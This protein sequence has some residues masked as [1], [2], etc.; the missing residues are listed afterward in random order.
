[1]VVGE[2]QILGQVKD[3]FAKATAYKSTG[4]LTNRLFTSAFSRRQAR[5]QRDRPRRR[6]RVGQLRGHCAGE[7]DLRRARRPRRAD[8]RRR[9]D[10]QAHRR[11]PAGAARAV[12]CR[13]PA[14]RSAPRRRSRD[15]MDGRAVPWI[16]IDQ[17]LA[18]AD[19]VI[20]ATGAR[21]PVLTRGRRRGRDAPRRDRPLFLIDIAVPRDVEPDVGSLDQVFLYNIDDLRSDRE[22]EPGAAR[23]ASSNAPRPSSATRWQRFGTWMQSR[24]IIPTV[25]ALR[26]RFEAIR[27]SELQ[28]LEPKLAAPAAGG[29]RARRRDHPPDRREAAADADRTAQVGRRRAADRRVCGRA[30]PALRSDHGRQARAADNRARERFVRP[31]R[32]GTRGSPLALWQAR[33][34]ARLHRGSRTRGGTGDDQDRRRSAPGRAALGGRRQGALR[35]GNRGRAPRRRHR[36]RRPQREGHVG[37]CC[38]TA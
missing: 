35:Q 8:S 2:P 37:R 32:I 17:A 31:L 12:S 28:R 33:A 27:R 14:G 13:W 21:E 25:V 30:P 7:E 23:R 18:A 19:I 3:A 6:G 5:A 34:V 10:G 16:A 38:P 4:A 11:P 20:T 26:Q 24:E 9:R 36:S 29:A 15:A 22:G 1:M